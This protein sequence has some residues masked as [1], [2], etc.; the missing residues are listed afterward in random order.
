MNL[1][2]ELTLQTGLCKTKAQGQ[3]WVVKVHYCLFYRAQYG[4]NFYVERVYSVL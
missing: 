1:K 3:A 2:L 4:Y